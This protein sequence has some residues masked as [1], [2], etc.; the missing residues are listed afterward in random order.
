M[1]FVGCRRQTGWM[2]SSL[3]CTV[4]TYKK[5]NFEYSLFIFIYETNFNLWLLVSVM[6]SY[7]I[8]PLQKFNK[9]DPP[10]RPSFQS[11]QPYLQ[12]F[13]SKCSLFLCHQDGLK[14]KSV[15]S[16]WLRWQLTTLAEEDC[17]M[18]LKSP[19]SSSKCPWVNISFV[20]LM[21]TRSR[22]NFHTNF[23]AGWIVQFC[24]AEKQKLCDKLYWD[25]QRENGQI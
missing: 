25:Q 11:F 14:M 24:D 21:F 3:L 4:F 20:K 5:L 1:Y 22:M 6:I 17:E 15:G 10:S 8:M 13:L 9:H 2:I 16:K 19:E 18:E 23:K 12:V 7:S